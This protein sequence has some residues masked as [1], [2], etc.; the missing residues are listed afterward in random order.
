MRPTVQALLRVSSG[1]LELCGGTALMRF[2]NPK[3]PFE[4]FGKLLGFLNALL[5]LDAEPPSRNIPK[6]PGLLK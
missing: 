2:G 1:Q 3:L 4:K 6:P 5:P